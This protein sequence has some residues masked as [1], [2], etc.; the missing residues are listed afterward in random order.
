ME[1][2]T[3]PHG[4]TPHHF[5]E[6]RRSHKDSLERF[7]ERV[8]LRGIEVSG[9]STNIRGACNLWPF[10]D[11]RLIHNETRP[12]EQ[13][14]FTKEKTGARRPGLA[15]G[16][17]SY[18]AQACCSWRR[19]ISSVCSCSCSIGRSSG[20]WTSVTVMFTSFTRRPARL[21]TRLIT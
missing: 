11:E 6:T 12:R 17:Y 3:V 4:C 5:R 19:A 20:T 10:A 14:A 16:R 13:R 8:R 7:A 2:H 21:S 18:P 9:I 15:S 1:V